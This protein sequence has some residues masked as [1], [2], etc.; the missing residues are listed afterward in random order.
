M[1][2]VLTIL[3]QMFLHYHQK[4]YLAVKVIGSSLNAKKVKIFSCGKTLTIIQ[5]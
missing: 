3:I 4:L 1:R 2:D 5:K